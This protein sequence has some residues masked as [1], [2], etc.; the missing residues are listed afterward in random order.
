[1]GG[2]NFSTRVSQCFEHH[3]VSRQ[4]L[5][6]S[7]QDGLL[8]RQMW[9]SLTYSALLMLFFSL[10]I[11]NCEEEQQMNAPVFPINI[12]CKQAVPNAL[13]WPK[14]KLS[15]SDKKKIIIIVI[16]HVNTVLSLVMAK[17]KQSH[18]KTKHYL[19]IPLLQMTKIWCPAAVCAI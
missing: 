1:M 4:Q 16:K 7:L 8:G 12:D 5:S 19:S 6:I 11:R 14:N 18:N 13:L 3:H 10:K 17:A 9:H 15:A 2:R